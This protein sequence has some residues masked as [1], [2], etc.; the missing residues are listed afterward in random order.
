MNPPTA[1]MAKY[2]LPETHAEMYALAT[3]QQCNRDS[4]GA[5]VR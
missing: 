4:K 3:Y 2:F 1:S 5:A